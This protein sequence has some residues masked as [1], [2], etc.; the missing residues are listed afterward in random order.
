M[1]IREIDRSAVD[2]LSNLQLVVLR[3]KRTGMAIDVSY[4]I[5]GLKWSVNKL[6]ISN[7]YANAKFEKGRI[8]GD[9]LTINPNVVVEK[10]IPRNHTTE[11]SQ[12]AEYSCINKAYKL[13]ALPPFYESQ[14]GVVGT[15]YN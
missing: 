5:E 6:G 9:N 7:Y 4:T 1:I 11:K 3:N 14:A 12:S 8:T 10:F 15:F 13:W 2:Y